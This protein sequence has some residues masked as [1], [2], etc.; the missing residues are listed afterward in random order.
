LSKSAH[1]AILL[2]SLGGCLGMQAGT[3]TCSSATGSNGLT[4]TVCGPLFST[5][6]YLDWG[7]AHAA[8]GY[9]GLGEAITAANSTGPYNG[10][11]QTY[12]GVGVTVSSP[13]G[14]NIGRVDNT[15]YAWDAVF[16]WTSPQIVAGYPIY[17]FAGHFGAPGTPGSTPPFGDNLLGVFETSA[18][19]DSEMMLSFDSPIQGVAFRISS[20]YSVDFTALLQAYDS[21]NTLLGSYQIVT[22]GLGG[23][24][25]GL[26]ALGSD[27]NPVPC[28]DA[29]QIQILAPGMS[30]LQLTVND[31]N[32]AVI[33]QLGLVDS[34]V[35]EPGTAAG[36]LAAIAVLFIA[37]RN[38][39]RAV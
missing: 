6:D 4:P 31:P 20:T 8:T 13:N 22:T 36:M 37:R 38:A 27:G 16:G 9:S 15:V 11:A 1:L 18:V 14:M 10:T 34:A 19:S 35:P 29:P 24:C 39:V 7:A 28:N 2:M 33:D 17:T 21:T 25:A 23:A 26:F 30:R 12:G 5:T 3:I 32:G